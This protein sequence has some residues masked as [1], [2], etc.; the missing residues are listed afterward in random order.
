MPV[1][2]LD[3]ALD[4]IESL[5]AAPEGMPLSDLARRLGMPKSAAHRLLATL[6]AR[7]YVAQDPV[8]QM[9]GLS[10][11]LA[12]LAFAMLDRRRLPDL[13]QGVLDELAR[14][15]REYCRLAL[16]EGGELIWVA[17]AQG[18]TQALRY[19]PEMGQTVVL[20]ATAT[21]KAWLAT[22]PEADALALVAARGFAVP[23]HFG[24]RAVRDLAALSEHLAATRRQGYGL[25]VDEGEPGTVA[26][27][28]AFRAWDGPDAP[29]AGTLSVA[30]PL[31]RLPPAAYPTLVAALRLAAG[32]MA[33]LW[34]LRRRHMA[35]LERPA[36]TSG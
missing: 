8:T 34:P 5:A 13:A 30:G 19:E 36:G 3:R 23:P 4:L 28:V 21:G 6:S 1:A 12:G 35:G 16:A 29:V 15:T 11:R 33:E 18:A 25:A 32:R 14:R 10:L 24:P 26:L 7:G 27:A 2:S 20:H 31:S 22:M 9:Y 17:R